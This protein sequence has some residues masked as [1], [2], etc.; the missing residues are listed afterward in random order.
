[1]KLDFAKAFDI[2]EHSAIVE[3]LVRLGFLARWIDWVK[4]ILSSGSAS[5]L[6]N[7]VHFNTKGGLDKVTPYPPCYLFGC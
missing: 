7:G 6:L 1:M 3:M 5:V 2:M 4:T